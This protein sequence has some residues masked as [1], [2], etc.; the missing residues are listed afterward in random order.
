MTIKKAYFYIRGE[1]SKGTTGAVSNSSATTLRT[2]GSLYTGNQS[3]IVPANSFTLVPNLYASAIDFTGLTRDGVSNLFYIWDSKKLS[4]SSLGVYQ[5]FSATNSFNCMVSGGSYVLGQPNT[6]IESGQAFFVQGN[7]IGG[8]IVLHESS[9]RGGSTGLGFRP[10]PS[11]VSKIE[12]RLYN[13]D[14]TDM[15]DA[16]SILFDNAYSNAVEEEDAPK[17]GNPGENFA[18][19]NSS[20]ILAVEGRKPL[21]HADVVQFRIWN[22]KQQQYTLELA[23]MRINN[24]RFECNA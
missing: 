17:I 20:K 11:S 5:T 16:A 6:L 18:L 13:S 19:E 15:R 8:S 10:A 2:A 7:S 1:R 4:G 9:K 22:L 21:K 23:A 12:T 3:T 14:G 24:G